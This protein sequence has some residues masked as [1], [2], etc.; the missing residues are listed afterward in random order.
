MKAVF[1]CY[2]LQ[3]FKI[4]S[5][6]FDLSGQKEVINSM[7]EVVKEVRKHHSI[8]SVG[9]VRFLSPVDDLEFYNHA[10]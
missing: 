4:T 10:I 9:V 7:L 3:V 8:H 1:T 2:G 6:W 5:L